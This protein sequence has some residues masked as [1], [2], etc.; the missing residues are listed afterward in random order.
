M[1]PPHPGKVLAERF[2]HCLVGS[3]VYKLGVSSEDF[4]ELVMGRQDITPEL[5]LV[6]ARALG[7]SAQYWIDLQTAHDVGKV[8]VRG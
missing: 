6:L 4:A 3:L 5:A 8:M 7:T 1:I 2:G